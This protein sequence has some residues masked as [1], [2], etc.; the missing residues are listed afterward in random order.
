MT[1]D[2][3]IVKLGVRGKSLGSFW[4]YAKEGFNKDEHIFQFQ[5]KITCHQEENKGGLSF[6]VM[7]F[8]K[9]EES[10]IEVVGE[11][12]R[13]VASNLEL[14]DK[15][16][17]E[18]QNKNEDQNKGAQGGRS[19]MSG[20]GDESSMSG[21]ENPQPSPSAAEKETKVEDIPY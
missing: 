12:I 14:Q 4:D 18:N 21:A 16:F 7:D 2:E 1:E 6:Y 11:K 3:K 9:G 15:S 19:S 5:T 8:V 10:N 13:E 20:A 17:A